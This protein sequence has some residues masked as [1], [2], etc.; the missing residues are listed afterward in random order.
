MSIEEPE[1]RKARRRPVVESLRPA[2]TAM[3]KTLPVQ[4]GETGFL[5][6]DVNFKPIY[7][8]GA[9]IELLTYPRGESASAASLQEQLRTLLRTK[10]FAPDSA[11]IDFQSGRRR[12]VCR[13]FLLNALVPPAGRQI[14]AFHLERFPRRQAASVDPARRYRLS[15]RERETLEHLKRGLKTWEIAERM[16]VSPN[17]VK[18]FIRTVASKVGASTRSGI[19]GKVMSGG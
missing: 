2:E 19:V 17:T 8:N 10:R 18:Q 5:L 13:S 3:L 4:D 1:A 7:A 16:H 15:P 12:Y 9:A 11:P 6:T 14:I